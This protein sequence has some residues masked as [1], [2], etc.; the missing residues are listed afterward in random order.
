MKFYNLKKK[1]RKW[2]L[3]RNWNLC[4]LFLGILNGT[5]TVE[6]SLGFSQLSIE[7]LRSEVK[8][9]SHA[10]L[11]ATPWTVACTKLLHPW[12]FQGKTTGVGCH[13]LL[14]GIF[15]TQGSNPGLSHCRQTLYLLSHQ[16]SPVWPS[17]STS[18]Y[19]HTHTHTLESRDLNRR[20]MFT[21]VHSSISHNQKW[22]WHKISLVDEQTNKKV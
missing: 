8:S 12:D 10:W 17:N 4:T 21:N 13:F 5:A 16:R 14:Q 15:P 7:L 6:K 18:R 11:F 9:L 19:T 22:E 2:V 1:N 20:H 3:G